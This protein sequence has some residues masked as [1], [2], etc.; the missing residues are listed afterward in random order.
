MN[1]REKV[2]LAIFI[3]CLVVLASF[4]RLHALTFQSMWL[5]ELYSLRHTIPSEGIGEPL[6]FGRFRDG[7]PPL[8]NILLW[9]WRT[10]F[11][12]GEY[13]VRLLPA[14]FG[15]LGVFGIYFLGKELFSR[16]TGIYAALFTA[17]LPFHIYYSQETRPYSLAFLLSIL[18]YY[19]LIKTIKH[20]VLKWGLLYVLVTTCLLFTHYFGIL[21]LGAQLVFVVVFF[22]S[23]RDVDQ[24]K[25]LQIL[26]SAG[27]LI[28]LAY[29]PWMGRIARL[30]Q[31]KKIWA[32]APRPDFFVSYFKSYFGGELYVIVLGVFLIGLFFWS[33]SRRD[34]FPSHK[35]LLISWVLVVFVI[36]Y[37]R[38]FTHAAILTP[39]NTIV[40]VPA[41][42]LMV[43][44]GLVRIKHNRLQSLLFVSLLLMLGVNL[45][46]TNGNYYKTVQ[47][48]QW[49]E[50]ALYVLQHD[51]EAKYPV[52]AD[53]S[54][55]YYFHDVFKSGRK[56]RRR[57]LVLK[58]ARHASRTV[59]EEKL[60]GFWLIEAH[61]FMDEKAFQ[62]LE[63]HFVVRDRVRLKGARVTLYVPKKQPA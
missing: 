5:D 54:I 42:V 12:S 43:C 18:S 44:M 38:S 61:R 4:L 40:T 56:L 62:Y 3:F 52:C 11:G 24:R 25:L 57:I 10:V 59:S 9:I 2:W 63:S 15:I 35:V 6:R 31:V 13:S 26:I 1:Q 55:N 21:I 30:M 45:F 51:P 41:F 36:P 27:I 49:R 22:L 28:V 58:A 53:K 23:H 29:L 34:E 60:P 19:F 8:F 17:V 14:I 32:E 39:R 46:H 16:K 33:K 47:K 50:A 7:S 20:R 37:I 48:E